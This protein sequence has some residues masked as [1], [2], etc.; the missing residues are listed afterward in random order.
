MKR[1]AFSAVIHGIVQGVAFRYHTRTVARERRLTGWVRN[2]PNG[3]VE[4][5]AEGDEPGLLSLSEWL[6]HGPA[7]ASV[8]KVDLTWK[9]PKKETDLFEITF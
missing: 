8:D 1:K 3:S 6:E 4:V 5:W 2:L 7:M 9:E